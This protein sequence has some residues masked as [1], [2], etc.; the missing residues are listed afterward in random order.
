MENSRTL[1]REAGSYSV[2]VLLHSTPTFLSRCEAT[3]GERNRTASARKELGATERA[4]TSVA[5]LGMNGWNGHRDTEDRF[6]PLL[7]SFFST[8]SEVE[9]DGELN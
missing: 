1:H 6:L 3:D 2:A 4:E 8:I 9:Q 7:L 5:S